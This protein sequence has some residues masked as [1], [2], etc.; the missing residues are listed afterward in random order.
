MLRIQRAT[1]E[2][3]GLALVRCTGS[4]AHLRKLAA[5]TGRLTALKSKGPSPTE[6]A[7]YAKFGLSFIEPEL[8]EGYNEVKQ[9][10]QGDASGTQTVRDICGELHA[11]STSSDGSNSIEQNGRRG[12]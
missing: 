7:L 6:E 11:H 2:N 5:V 3:W 1:Q 4:K 9:A 10:A 8:R 12:A